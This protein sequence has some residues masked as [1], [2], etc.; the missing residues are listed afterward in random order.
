ME[1]GLAAAFLIGLMGGVHCVGMCG[2]IVGALTVQTPRRRR[3][4]DLHLAYSTGRIASYAAAGAIMGMIGG[5]GLMFNQ[6]LPVQMLLYVLAN[7][8]LIGMG[9]YLAGLGK[10]LAR[11]EALGAWLWRRIQP[12]SARV[13]PADTLAKAFALGTL[14]GWLPCGLVYGMLATALVSGGAARGAA[15]ML[16]F[17]LGTLPNLLLAGMAFK[18]LRDITSNPRLRMAAGALVACFGVVGLARAAHMGEH[19]RKGLLAIL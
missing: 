16:A 2:G 3:A 11:V 9:L 14:W 17:G 8:V 12:Y 4:W 5:A 18:R 6:V 10:Q 7:L 15:V 13:L 19:I 1:A